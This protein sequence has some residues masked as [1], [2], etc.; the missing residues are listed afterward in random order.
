MI[1]YTSQKQ[2]SK[3]KRNKKNKSNKTNRHKY[4]SKIKNYIRVNETTC[5]GL[6]G[7]HHQVLQSSKSLRTL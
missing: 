4:K 5:F 3:P 1:K 7:G 2:Q 6:L